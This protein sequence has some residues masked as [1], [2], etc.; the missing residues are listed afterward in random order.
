MSLQEPRQDIPAEQDQLVDEIRSFEDN[1]KRAPKAQAKLLKNLE[2][3]IASY[4]AGEVVACF[5]RVM[6]SGIK[7]VHSF[8]SDVAVS[9]WME[10]RKLY[11]LDAFP[12]GLDDGTRWVTAFNLIALGTKRKGLLSTTTAMEIAF[13]DIAERLNERGKDRK[14]RLENER[15]ANRLPTDSMTFDADHAA[16]ALTS[17]EVFVCQDALLRRSCTKAA[18]R[19]DNLTA[20]AMNPSVVGTADELE[21]AIEAASS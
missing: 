10:F 13:L 19:L 9:N 21:E 15:K 8:R 14:K 5:N 17:C 6:N 11:S 1:A 2:S 4:A 12:D 16:Y 7:Q 20:G 18:K 3:V